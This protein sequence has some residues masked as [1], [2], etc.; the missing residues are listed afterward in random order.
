MYPMYAP[1]FVRA[2]QSY[3][4]E[5][6]RRWSR[7]HGELN[8]SVGVGYTPSVEK[9]HRRVVLRR[10]VRVVLRRAVAR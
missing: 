5:G 8:G 2:D 4:L 10:A 6:F 1:E 9:G 3:R 7:H